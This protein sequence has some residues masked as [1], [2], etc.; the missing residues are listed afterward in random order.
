[1]SQQTFQILSLLASAATWATALIALMSLLSIRSQQ[2]A[3]HRPELTP[4]RQ[5]IHAIAS[6]SNGA[7]SYWTWTEIETEEAVAPNSSEPARPTK[8]VLRERYGVRLFNLGTGAAKDISIEWKFA[9]EQLVQRI[10]QLSQRSFAEIYIEHDIKRQTLSLKT[11]TGEGASYFL[12]HDRH[13]RHDYILPCSIENKGHKVFLPLWYIEL[14]SM[15][16]YL[17]FTQKEKEEDMDDNILEIEL[18]A[19]FADIAGTR[20][21]TRFKLRTK[22]MIYTHSEP[23]TFEA[24][25][26]PSC[27]G[28]VKA[29]R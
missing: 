22:P 21:S 14:V 12:K 27:S 20:Y 1:M 2:K 13:S 6:A 9:I 10:N 24:L 8:A 25:L 16:L 29:P 28:K 17:A 4:T 15:Y 5:I 7:P 19:K 26:V 23:P 3:A 11:K 18:L